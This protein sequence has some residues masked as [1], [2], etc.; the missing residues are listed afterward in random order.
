MITVTVKTKGDKVVIKS[1]GHSGFAEK[2]SDIVC[3][4]VSALVFTALTFFDNGRENL[5][6][7][8]C[9]VL[10]GFAQL[11]FY[12]KDARMKA[13]VEFFETG[14]GL[15]ADQYPEHVRLL[16]SHGGGYEDGL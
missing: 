5:D 4:A 9:E 10:N 13:A 1:Q 16:E 2:G 7:T 6:I 11:V 8:R 14:I 3:S 12:T 15:I